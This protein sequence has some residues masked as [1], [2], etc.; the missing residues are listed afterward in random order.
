MH[1]PNPKPCYTVWNEPLEASASMSTHSRRNICFN[2]TGDISTLK[3]SSLKLVDKFTY[4]GSSVSSTETDIDTWLAKAWTAYNS[5]S[6][7]WTLD[8]IDKVKRSFFQAA[9]MLILLYERPTWTLTKRLEKK[10]HKNAASNI[11]QL[12]ET[13]SHKAAIQPPTT[14]HENYQNRRTRHAG[15]SWRSRDELI[16]DVFLWTLSHGRTCSNI[17]AAA[18]CRYVM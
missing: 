14:H 1:L 16:S 13:A 10:L 8:L 2:L 7:I 6:V 12:L 9:V 11:E 4:R 3:G 5:L 17:H 15:H 18:L